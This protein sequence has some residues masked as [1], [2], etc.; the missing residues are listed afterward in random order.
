MVVTEEQ[1]VGIIEREPVTASVVFVGP[2]T[3]QPGLIFTNVDPLQV[4]VGLEQIEAGVI[5]VAR[6][7]SSVPDRSTFELVALGPDQPITLATAYGVTP[8]QRRAAI[9]LL[10]LW[11]EQMANRFIAASMAP[12]PSPLSAIVVPRH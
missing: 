2:G 7:E 6:A 8:T 10:R 11:A 5:K 9:I 4:L 12:Q 1:P 3:K